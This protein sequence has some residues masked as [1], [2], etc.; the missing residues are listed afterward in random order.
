MLNLG[1]KGSGRPQATKRNVQNSKEGKKGKILTREQN[2]DA[3]R[4]IILGAG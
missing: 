4:K 3:N 2:S 1:V